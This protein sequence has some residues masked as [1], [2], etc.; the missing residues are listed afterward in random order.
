MTTLTAD[1]EN[2]T[3]VDV[4]T[5]ENVATAINKPAALKAD[6]NTFNIVRLTASLLVIFAHCFPLLAKPDKSGYGEW[7]GAVAVWV[8]FI[9]SGFLITGSYLHNRNLVNFVCN[10]V[11]RVW[12]A[13]IA[14]TLISVFIIGPCVTNLSPGAYFAN[15]AT[16]LY[17]DNMKLLW[18]HYNLPGV[19]DNNHYPHA[20]NG[21]LWSIPLEILMY[22]STCI[23]GVA[24]VL[25]RRHLA[26]ALW[27]ILFIS[28]LPGIC[29]ANFDKWQPIPWLGTMASMT[30]PV[31]FY[32]TGSLLYLWKDKIRPSIALALI[33]LVGSGI[34]ASQVGFYVGLTFLMPLG[35]LTF[36]LTPTRS[37]I[38][39][40]LGD[41]SYGIYLWAFPVQQ[42][43]V[44]FFPRMSFWQLF[45]SA[46]V[47]AIV[48]GAISW[49]LIEKPCLSL[50]KKIAK[51][52]LNWGRPAK[53]V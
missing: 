5:V 18:V 37:N 52:K 51:L 24:G 27:T 6:G 25:H 22:L 14:V 32:C 36:A 38:L 34:C 35:V 19:F 41:Y 7:Q 43:L 50:K 15:P 48:C 42:L 13:L 11:L 30:Y 45:I 49:H 21:S 28:G 23:L 53:T 47:L 8:F 26:L 17:L 12:P 40:K 16:Y 33:L 29:P 44:H 20:V 3:A 10:R 39:S 1:I 2:K 4:A 9:I 31:L 46:S